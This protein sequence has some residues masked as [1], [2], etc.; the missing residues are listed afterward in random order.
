MSLA[1][2][3]NPSGVRFTEQELLDLLDR[4]EALAPQAVLL[5]D[6]TYRQAV[7]GAAPVPGSAAGRVTPGRD[8]RLGVEGARRTGAAG[9]LA[10]R[11]RPATATSG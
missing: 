2:P 6:E 4:I 9:R 8:R 11:R 5:V 1:S 7:Y 3:Q 10:D